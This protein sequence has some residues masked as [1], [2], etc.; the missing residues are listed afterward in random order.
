[1]VVKSENNSSL[2][3]NQD[4]SSSLISALIGGNSGNKKTQN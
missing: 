2:K 1:M 4:N 3:L